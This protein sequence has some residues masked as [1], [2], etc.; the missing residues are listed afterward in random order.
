MAPANDIA[1]SHSRT[2]RQWDGN[3]RPTSHAKPAYSATW[4]EPVK[5]RPIA[6]A[7]G[8]GSGNSS[9]SKAAAPPSAAALVSRP[10]IRIGAACRHSSN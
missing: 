9:T 5:A 4:A 10:A 7:D 6:P 1:P 3:A 2:P 8:S